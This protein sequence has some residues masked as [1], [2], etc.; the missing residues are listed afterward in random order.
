M[1]TEVAQRLGRICEAFDKTVIE[2]LDMPAERRIWP[3]GQ[4]IAASLLLAP[5]IR[6]SE[7]DYQVVVVAGEYHDRY[8]NPPVQVHAWIMLHHTDDD[9]LSEVYIV[10]PTAS[11]FYAHPTPATKHWAVMTMGDASGRYVPRDWLSREAEDKARN[12]TFVNR[13][14]RQGAYSTLSTVHGRLL[15]KGRTV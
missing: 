8:R 10:D 15:L 3:S 11:Q 9:K 14:D 6:A 12:V 2:M 7:K 1:P 4:C 5:L 13:S